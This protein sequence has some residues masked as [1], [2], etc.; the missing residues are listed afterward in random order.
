MQRNLIRSTFLVALM[1]MAA[2][3]HAAGN[4]AGG[5]DHGDAAIGEPGDAA[6]I[7][8]T[9]RVDM[10]DTMR[11]TPALITAQRGETIRFEVV[12]SGRVRHEMTLGTEA[13]LSAHAEQMRQHPEMEHA[14]GNAVSVDPGQT[15]EIVWHFTQPGTVEFGC[16]LPGHFEAGMR[17]AVQVRADDAPAAATAAAPLSEGE[18]KK[19]DTPAAKLTIQHG[20]LVN[21]DMPAMT[22]VFRVQDPT[23]LSR[24]QVGSKVRFTADKVNGALTVTALEV[25]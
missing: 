15:G 9:V 12:N 2:F 25:E 19:I 10:A 4:H 16:L 11:F 7:T 20:P 6:Q 24:V 14:H 18:I 13:D 8:R 23:M 22:M 1:S 3:A 17:G 21:L 5:H